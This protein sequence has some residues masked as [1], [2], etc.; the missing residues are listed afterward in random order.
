MAILKGAKF[1]IGTSFHLTAF[2]IIFNVPFLTIGMES[3]RARVNNILE[4]VGLEK[5]FV[6]ENDNYKE[7]IKELSNIFPNYEKLKQQI[8]K[9]EHF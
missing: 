6:T 8:E 5:Q 3:N 4:L 9:S 7:K 1:A 2:S